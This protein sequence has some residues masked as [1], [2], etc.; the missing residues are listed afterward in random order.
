M[1]PNDFEQVCQE[2]ILTPIS[3]AE[4]F[5]VHSQKNELDL[6]LSPHTKST[7]NGQRLKCET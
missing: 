5:N 3:G 6:C 7:Q 2:Q 1:Q 4:K